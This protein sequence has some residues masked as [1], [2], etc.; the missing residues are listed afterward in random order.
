MDDLI[1]KFC[2]DRRSWMFVIAGT[3]GMSLVFVMPCVDEYVAVCA[4]KT[5][6]AEKLRLATEAA[7][8]LAGFEQRRAEQLVVVQERLGKTL[9]DQNEA[10]YRN[11]IVKLVRDAGCQLRRLNIATPTS[12]VWGQADDPLEKSARKNLQPSG[13]QLERRQINLSLVGHSAN[14]RQ[15]LERL[16]NEDKQVYVQAID[17]KP[18]AGDGRRVELSME[19]WYFTLK[20]SAA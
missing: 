15:L 12:R 6:I 10:E 5:E 18:G 16:E 2:E 19:L 3:L 20:R 4:E 1:V 14:V 8:L 7:K 13:F 11:T 17:L 9:N